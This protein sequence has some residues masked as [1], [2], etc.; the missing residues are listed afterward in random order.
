V[1]VA[2]EG[3]PPEWLRPAALAEDKV[4]YEARAKKLVEEFKKNFRQFEADVPRAV[5]EA[6]P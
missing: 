4:Q 2:C 5:L 1:P 3:V 6:L